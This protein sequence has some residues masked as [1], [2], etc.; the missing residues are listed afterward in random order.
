MSFRLRSRMTTSKCWRISSHS[1]SSWSRQKSGPMSFMTA[2]SNLKSSILSSVRK[3]PNQK[4]I[5]L[6]HSS[7][8]SMQRMKSASWQ[9]L[10]RMERT[11]IIRSWLR[12]RTWQ[13]VTGRHTLK[14]SKAMQNS[15]RIWQMRSIASRLRMKSSNSSRIIRSSPLSSTSTIYSHRWLENE[16][17]V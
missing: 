12:W 10:L 5:W 17:K 14:R 9:L 7:E 3:S 1:G 16:I 13:N 6:L 4:L 2:H 11:S 15:L 8:V